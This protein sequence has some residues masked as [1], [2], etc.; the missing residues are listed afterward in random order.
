MTRL[1][2]RFNDRACA[3][4]EIPDLPIHAFQHIGDHKI[5]PQGGGGGGGG[6]IKVIAPIVAIVATVYA[7]PVVG[8]AIAK[9]VLGPAAA[10]TIGAT[11]TAAIGA[12]AIG[13]ATSAVNAAVA[14]K[15]L[16]GVLKAGA[17]GAASGA[18]GGAA[19]AQL[20]AGANAVARGAVSGATSGAVGASLRGRDVGQGALIGGVGGG[21][22]GGLT[23]ALTDTSIGDVEAQEGG[24]YGEQ[25]VAGTSTGLTPDLAKA[26]GRFGGSQA[27]Q[28]T[29]Q[30]LAPTPGQAPVPSGQGA[31][32]PPP[33]GDATTT[34][35][36]APGS[37]A[38]AQALRAGSPVIGGGGE[39]TT[40]RPVWNI[41]SLRVKDETGS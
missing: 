32:T 5:K 17:I 33:A 19:G 40:G 7:G 10:A 9:S 3:L 27:A 11:A 41:A 2:G 29:A 25:G 37:A 31:P 21:V 34:G 8:A 23:N 24:F 38:L 1:P 13:G 12:A 18:A 39:Q 14:G 28:L 20:G 16:D 15:N 26:I 6:I 4:L 30:N 36:P 35:Q 22:A